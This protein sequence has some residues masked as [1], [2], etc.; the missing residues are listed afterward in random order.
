MSG[1]KELNDTIITILNIANYQ[2]CHLKIYLCEVFL[3]SS[4]VMFLIIK[5]SVSICVLNCCQ[6]INMNGIKLIASHMF[7]RRAL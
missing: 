7:T 3:L 6:K 4:H 2:I 1:H 5:G